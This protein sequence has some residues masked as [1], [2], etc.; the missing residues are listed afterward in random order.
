MTDKLLWT[1]K[2]KPH[3]LN[4]IVSCDRHI[5]VLK[6]LLKSGNI[7]HLIFYGNSGVGKT[8]TI[9][10]CINEIYGTNIKSMV[11]ELN[12][13]D[14]RGIEV[15]REKI[16]TFASTITL[17]NSSVKLIILEEADLMTAD[18]QNALKKIIETY[19]SNCKFCILCN[20]I[21]KIIPEVQSRCIKFRF[22]QIKHQHAFSYI[23]NI[24]ECENINISD[25]ALNI[26]IKNGN[27][28]LRKM[29]NMLQTVYNISYKRSNNIN[30]TH[31]YKVLNIITEKDIKKLIIIF[32]ENNY[33]S[34]FKLLEEYIYKYNY[35]I[36]DIVNI[37]YEHL[38]EFNN[39][40]LEDALISLADL[41][42]QTEVGI[43]INIVIG[44]LISIIL[45]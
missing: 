1:V 29:V 5:S 32:K 20:N 41:E 37:M 43:P 7:P 26:I 30:D 25:K 14:E 31:I 6:N 9:Q 23:K 39:I 19:I 38:H 34:I 40:N 16:S 28:D 17:F 15:I 10:C 45:R 42:V 27:G 11:L 2:Y 35:S 33:M 8:S 4:E 18:A 12:A 21:N 22:S 24:C 44:T 13:S 36:I 3:N